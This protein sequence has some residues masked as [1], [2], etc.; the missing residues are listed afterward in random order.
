MFNM[1]KTPEAAEVVFAEQ[2][3]SAVKKLQSLDSRSNERSGRTTAKTKLGL[4][5]PSM[6][7]IASVA[8]AGIAS[9]S[10]TSTVDQVGMFSNIN[11]R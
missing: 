7:T 5:K 9:V 2:Y 10:A 3:Q 1:E 6:S 4:G 8:A 11:N